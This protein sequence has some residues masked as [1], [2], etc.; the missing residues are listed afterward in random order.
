[1]GLLT[2]KRAKQQFC[3]LFDLVVKLLEQKNITKF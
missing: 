2:E 3:Q 1:M